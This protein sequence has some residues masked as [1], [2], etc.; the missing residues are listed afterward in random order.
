MG[1]CNVSGLSH[2]ADVEVIKKRTIE[3]ETDEE[4]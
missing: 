4:W 3:E 1:K 2:C